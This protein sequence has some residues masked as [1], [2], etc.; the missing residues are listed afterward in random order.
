MYNVKRNVS[1][2]ISGWQQT[3]KKHS[4]PLICPGFI[5]RYI[6]SSINTYITYI[7]IHHIH[8]Y[9]HILTHKTDILNGSVNLISGNNKALTIAH[10]PNATVPSSIASYT[11]KRRRSKTI[12]SLVIHSSSPSTCTTQQ[13]Q[14]DVHIQLKHAYKDIVYLQPPRT[15]TASEILHMSSEL[16]SSSRSINVL[17]KYLKSKGNNYII[18]MCIASYCVV[19][20]SMLPCECGI[21]KC[22][23][24]SMC[25]CVYVIDIDIIPSDREVRAYAKAIEYQY[26][27]A[28]YIIGDKTVD[29]ARVKDAN[30][31]LQD[32]V[33]VLHKNNKYKSYINIPPDKTYVQVSVDKGSE[34][35]KL[36]AQVINTECIHSVNNVDVLAVYSGMYISVNVAYVNLMFAFLYM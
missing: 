27:H 18:Y 26:E 20:V 16:R 28:L 24:F 21:G 25:I 32:I 23:Y 17:R 3:P 34:T 29:Y 11:T 4:C 35:T 31:V 33:N 9:A 19:F 6:V 14:T 8:T 7:H 30:T 10:I 22:M 12:Q 1:K 36:T 2:I 5:D 15:L 13:Q